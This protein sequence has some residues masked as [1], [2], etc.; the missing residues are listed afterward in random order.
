MKM[1][2]MNNISSNINLSATVPLLRI[3]YNFF[4]IYFLIMADNVDLWGHARGHCIVNIGGEK[5]PCTEYTVHKKRN[6]HDCATCEH[7][8]SKHPLVGTVS[9]THSNL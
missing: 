3:F 9:D 4:L 1:S 7:P 2:Y 6:R 8:G 5:C